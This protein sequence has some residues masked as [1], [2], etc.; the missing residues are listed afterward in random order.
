MAGNR[1]QLVAIARGVAWLS[2]VAVV[3]CSKS[4][5]PDKAEE[6]A[7]WLEVP[8]Q[9][10]PDRCI[11]VGAAMDLGNSGDARAVEPLIGALDDTTWAVRE[12]AAEGL[13]KL[14]DARAVEPLIRCLKEGNADLRNTVIEALLK[15]GKP[16]VEPLIACL[17]DDDPFVR[18]RAAQALGKL[19]DARAEAPLTGCLKDPDGDVRRAAAAALD[20]LSK[21]PGK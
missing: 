7:S 9:K 21:P 6:P 14:R 10:C 11:R 1:R 3:G 2:L 17:K 12:M 8:W 13:G 4:D 18:E 15:I 16:S 20:T 19:G 5:R